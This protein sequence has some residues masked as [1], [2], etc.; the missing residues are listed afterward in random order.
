MV[1]VDRWSL[2]R[3]TLLSLK[4]PMDQFTMVSLDRWSFRQV[5]LYYNSGNS[6]IPDTLGPEWTVLIIEVSSFQGL[7]M[8]YDEAWRIILVPVVCVL[9]SGASAIQG[10]GL[11]GFHCTRTYVRR[12][13]LY[14]V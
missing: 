7:K 8:Y 14:T 6:S 9:I 4:W 3:G 5:S 10:S 12:Y 11:E 13:I 1:F 2:Y